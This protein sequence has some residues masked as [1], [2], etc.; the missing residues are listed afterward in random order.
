MRGGESETVGVIAN[1]FDL[2]NDKRIN[3]ARATPEKVLAL[4]VGKE[5][6]RQQAADSGKDRNK[7]R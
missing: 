2:M 6:K 1:I 7:K 3:N 4:A 5:E